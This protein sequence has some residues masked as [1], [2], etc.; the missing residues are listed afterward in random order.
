MARVR[1][2]LPT[3]T[4]TVEA[5]EMAAYAPHVPPPLLVP[6][7]PLPGI[8][9]I[10]N[11]ILD[12]FPEPCIVMADDDFQFVKVLGGS[13]RTIKRP[14][15]VQRL[16]ENQLAIACDLDIGVFNW[17]PARPMTKHYQ[18]HDPFSFSKDVWGVFG[19]RGNARHRRFDCRADGLEDVDMTLQA[20]REDRIVLT[21]LRFH[22]DVGENQV[23]AGGNTTADTAAQRV[24]ATTYLREKWGP[25]I[26]PRVSGRAPKRRASIPRRQ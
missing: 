10:R 5:S 15:D 21:D 7:P 13:M 25:I 3:A 11:W 4:V 12:T 16:I 9:A 19:M 26:P 24:R 20:L 8:A 22:F 14:A 18:A 1:R 23:T 17:N 2:L 6:H